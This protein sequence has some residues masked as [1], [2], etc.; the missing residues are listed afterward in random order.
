LLHAGRDLAVDVVATEEG[1]AASLM[2]QRLDRDSVT[3]VDD[4][5]DN[6]RI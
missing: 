3:L 4:A 6:A 1:V 2:R 5:A